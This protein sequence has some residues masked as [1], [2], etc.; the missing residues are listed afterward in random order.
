MARFRG[1]L[2]GQ[3]GMASRLGSKWTGLTVTCDG[4]DNGV[5]VEAIPSTQ[6]SKQ[7]CF[8]IAFTGGSNNGKASI[9]L[10]YTDGKVRVSVGFN[11]KDIK[12]LNHILAKYDRVQSPSDP[13]GKAITDLSK[14][15]GV[16]ED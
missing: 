8:H 4:W 16:K 14:T 13:L 15:A 12:E 7:D 11:S 1:T 6:E 5:T 10:D 9:E 2:I 3:R